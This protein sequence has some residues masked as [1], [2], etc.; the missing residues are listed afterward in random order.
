MVVWLFKYLSIDKY[1]M[2]NGHG[3][4]NDDANILGELTNYGHEM[5]GEREFVQSAHTESNKS[6]GMWC[7]RQM[8]MKYEWIDEQ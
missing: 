2:A 1:E 3:H 4:L 6:D 5:D 8:R 7:N